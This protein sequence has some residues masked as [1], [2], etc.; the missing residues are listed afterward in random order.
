MHVLGIPVEES[1]LSSCFD[2]SR[3]GLQTQPKPLTG[4]GYSPVR[5]QIPPRIPPRLRCG[6]SRRYSYGLSGET[7][8]TV[9]NLRRPPVHTNITHDL[10]AP[11]TR[12]DILLA[13]GRTAI[14]ID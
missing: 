1:E 4:K 14:S 11:E 10:A 3:V 9:S 7:R 2:G 13:P 12:M 8:P 5:W 6:C